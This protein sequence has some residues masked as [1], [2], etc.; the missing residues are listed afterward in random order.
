MVE[1]DDA[2]LFH[3]PHESYVTVLRDDDGDH[4]RMLLAQPEYAAVPCSKSVGRFGRYSGPFQIKCP[5]NLFDWRQ[6]TAD[7]GPEAM[8]F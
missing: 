8:D 7:F 3:M 6:L 4:S 2:V 5:P 1:I